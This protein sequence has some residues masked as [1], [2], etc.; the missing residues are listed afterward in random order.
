MWNQHEGHL[1][2]MSW[3]LHYTGIHH[4]TLMVQVCVCVHVIQR[5]HQE[6]YFSVMYGRLTHDSYTDHLIEHLPEL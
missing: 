6:M 1:Y 5:V 3:Y 2:G 4:C